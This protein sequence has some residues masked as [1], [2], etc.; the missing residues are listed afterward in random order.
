M[1]TNPIV[2][3]MIPCYNHAAFLGDCLNSILAQ[4]YEQIELLICDD[5]STDDSFA[6]IQSYESR[7]RERFSD[8]SI[9]RNETNCGVTKNVNRMLA[10]AKG[11]YLKTIASDDAMAPNA[12]SAMVSYLENNP[13][14]DIAVSNGRK[15]REDQHYPFA[16]GEEKIYVLSPDFSER[17]MFERTARCN[18][19]S[20]PAA[21]VRRSVYETYGYYDEQLK[22]E[23]YEFWLRIL[24]DGQVRFGFLDQELIY[25]RINANSM[26]SM[27]G[28]AGL[29]RRRK[30]IHQSEMDTLNK[31]RNYLEKAVYAEI[32]LSRIFSERWLAV[33][34]RL[35]DWE[36]ELY[37][38]WKAFEGWK[39]L[40]FGKRL[41]FRTLSARQN[42][43]K[44]L[45]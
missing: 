11:A 44:R 18:Q 41:R 45:R 1:K 16:S 35:T 9:M 42:I 22:V 37:Q 29:A 36:A 14:I 7:L 31:Y 34:H 13:Q 15:V 26:T 10:Q 24:K 6:V 2:S 20:A 27:T 32:V 23:D 3:V 38:Q 39:D 5:C 4:D 17:G 43:K 8:V 12:I 28:N 25:Y 19:I 21:M 40:P 30:L 33:A